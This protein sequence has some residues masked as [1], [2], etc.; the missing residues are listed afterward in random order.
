MTREEAISIMSV[1]VHMLEPQYDTDRIE[2][3]VEMA[4][5]A[6]EQESKLLQAL[7]QEKGAYNALVKN[8]QCTDC[9]SRQAA[10]RIAEQGQIQGYEWQFK[11]LSAL[12]SVKPQEPK[13]GH[14]VELPTHESQSGLPWYEC[15]ECNSERCIAVLRDFKY[16]PN[17]GAKMAESEVGE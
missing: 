7:E 5:K 6:L 11:E 17:C 4:I 9:I 12:P 1:I 2:D 8:I 15:S 3:A 14:W 10:I 13:T 16:C